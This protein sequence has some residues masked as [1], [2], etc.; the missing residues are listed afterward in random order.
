MMLLSYFLYY[1]H[2]MFQ[3]TTVL[4]PTTVDNPACM[5][6]QALHVYKSL[7][8]GNSGDVLK[9]TSQFGITGNVKAGPPPHKTNESSTPAKTND[10]E[11]QVFSFQSPEKEH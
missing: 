11:D 1:F 7:I 3:G 6:A 8:G 10:G 9:D 2:L 5:M 4:L